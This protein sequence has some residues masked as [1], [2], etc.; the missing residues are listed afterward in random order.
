[1]VKHN[2]NLLYITTL[3]I[4]VTMTVSIIGGQEAFAASG[5][6]DPE[7]NITSLKLFDDPGMVSMA[8]GTDGNPVIVN[9]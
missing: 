9:T 3:L 4:A 5:F 7:S 6:D 1:M 2:T 8:I